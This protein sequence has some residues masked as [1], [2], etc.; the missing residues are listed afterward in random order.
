MSSFRWSETPSRPEY[1]NRQ[2]VGEAIPEDEGRFVSRVFEVMTGGRDEL[3]TCN[4]SRETRKRAEREASLR[5]QHAAADVGT[6]IEMRRGNAAA[7]RIAGG[8]RRHYKTIARFCHE[9][10]FAEPASQPWA[11]LP[12]RS[13]VREPW[14]DKLDLHV[15]FSATRSIF[16]HPGR[17]VA[18]GRRTSFC[19][20]SIRMRSLLLPTGR[21]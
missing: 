18:F 14:A 4:L 5:G 7:D 11:V 12:R 9:V 1:S 21:L 16:S 6:R 17:Q 10:R 13:R 8:H 15:E 2:F 3:Y 19:Y 20:N